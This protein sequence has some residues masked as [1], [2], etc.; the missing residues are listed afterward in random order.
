MLVPPSFQ[1]SAWILIWEA[2]RKKPMYRYLFRSDDH[3]RVRE[4][5]HVRCTG[6][7]LLCANSGHFVTAFENM[8]FLEDNNPSVSCLA[9]RFHVNSD[10][11]FPDAFL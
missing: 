3:G 10:A 4:S 2:H 7:C 9:L 1:R 11:A 8:M 6:P 5:E